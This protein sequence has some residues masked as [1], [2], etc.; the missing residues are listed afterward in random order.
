[1]VISWS[2]N[3]SFEPHG[4]INRRKIMGNDLYKK[5]YNEY[6][7]VLK[8]LA[9]SQKK[10][11]DFF[12]SIPLYPVEEPPD[13]PLKGKEIFQQL[14]KAYGV[15]VEKYKVWRNSLKFFDL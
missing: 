13:L 11:K 5:N 2:G 14:I 12:P 15:Y 6:I 1:V 3:C 9:D 10:A 4:S 8:E 7:E